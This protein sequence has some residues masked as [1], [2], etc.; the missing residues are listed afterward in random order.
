MYGKAP[1][2][3]TDGAFLWVC[4]VLFLP[5]YMSSVH[6]IEPDRLLG[7]KTNNIL[8]AFRHFYVM[9]LKK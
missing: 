3:K 8:F 5:D 1:L 2:V 6:K 9:I 7:N 4:I